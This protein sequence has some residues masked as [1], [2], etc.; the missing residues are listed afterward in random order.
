MPLSFVS[1]MDVLNM[2]QKVK[3][4]PVQLEPST[5]SVDEKS[6]VIE[7]TI[8]GMMCAIGCTA[9]IEKKLQ[10]TQGVTS[11]AVDF[12]SKLA[13]ITF[14]PSQINSEKIEEV[15][16]RLD[17]LIRSLP[18]IFST[19]SIFPTQTFHEFDHILL[20]IPHAAGRIES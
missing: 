13:K 6:Q 20:Y 8:E 16:T 5:A 10:T 18:S 3:T 2:C 15:I 11:A 14:D 19:K 1:F 4:P 12:D 17:L 9:T 7:M